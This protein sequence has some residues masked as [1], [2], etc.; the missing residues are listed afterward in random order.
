MVESMS[1]EPMTTACSHGGIYSVNPRLVT[2]DFSSNVNPLGIS[3]NAL[4][5]I[6]KSIGKLSSLYPDPKCIDLKKGI[7]NYLDIGLKLECICVGN[8]ATEIIHDFA[9][10]FVRNKVL[11]PAPTFCE[12]EIASRRMG[13]NILFIP[14]KNMTLDTELII[15]QAKKQDA[16]FLCNPNN[17]TGLLS[18]TAIKKIVESIDSSTKVMIDECFI[19]L[20]D[21]HEDQKYS[22]INKINE[23]DN[24]VILRSLTKSFGLAGLRVGYSVC[25][26]GLASRLS[27]NS[28]TW[29]VNGVA[30][31]AA[32]A[33]LKDRSHLANAKAVIKKERKY[34]QH[35]IEKKMQNFTPCK[36]DVNFFLIHLKK[37]NSIKVR[38]SMLTK[39]GVLVR[40][41]STFTG[42]GHEYIRVA[43]KKHKEN[44]ILLDA[45]ELA[46]TR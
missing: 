22:M 15:E 37:K 13:A 5:A 39:S 16:I 11:I 1:R 38:D 2:T 7:L 30:Q 23:F 12:Y 21:G 4:K 14:L 18:T 10:A 35:R 31:M 46:D 33:A 40:D 3:E 19:E 20:V 42:M 43:V 29:N 44:L 25:N 27:A 24:L 9:R 26:P 36:S 45:M 34:M 32:I 8:G 41:C 6:Q 17:P 28:I